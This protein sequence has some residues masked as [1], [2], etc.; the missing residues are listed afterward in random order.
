MIFQIALFLVFGSLLFVS[1]SNA[2]RRD[3]LTAEEIEIV[4]DVQEIDKRMLV[5][6]KA[7]ERRFWVLEGKENL[8]QQQKKRV[9]KDLDIWGELPDGNKTRLLTDID[10]IIDEAVSKIEDVADRDEKSKLLPI[11]VHVLADYSKSAIPRLEKFAE[12]SKV[13]REI[14]VVNSAVK[15]C[16]DIIEAASKIERPSDKIM[17][18]RTKKI[19]HTKVPFF[20]Q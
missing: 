15:N 8:D 6:I 1:D 3:H 12:S 5:F 7:I 17:K 11:A 16:N 4:R 9:K 19:G 10:K 18:K 20:I 13:R 14:V 2:Q